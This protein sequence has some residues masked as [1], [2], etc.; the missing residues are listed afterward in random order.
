MIAS[1][2]PVA[3]PSTLPV[4]PMTGATKKKIMTILMTMVGPE[5]RQSVEAKAR[6]M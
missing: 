6:T 2:L 5:L 1:A 4:T 3:G